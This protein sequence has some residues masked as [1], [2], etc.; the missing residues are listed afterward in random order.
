MAFDNSNYQLE[1]C[2]MFEGDQKT[3]MQKVKNKN[4]THR[5]LDRYE[6]IRCINHFTIYIYIF[7]KWGSKE[8]SNLS[9]STSL[10]TSLQLHSSWSKFGTGILCTKPKMCSILTLFFK[11]QET[12]TIYILLSPARWTNTTEEEYQSMQ[13]KSLVCW[14]SPMLILWGYIVL[15]LPES[16]AALLKLYW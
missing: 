3:K 5:F 13:Q 6:S 1:A 8:Q 14:P 16:T 12:P 7:L 9:M 4:R 15:L 10:K 2:S 11:V